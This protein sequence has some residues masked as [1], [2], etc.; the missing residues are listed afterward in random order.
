MLALA[1]DRAHGAFPYLVTPEHTRSARAILGPKRWLCVEQMILAETDPG[2]AREVGRRAVASYL[3]APGYR[4][5]LLRLG[6]T[7]DDVEARSVRLVDGLVAWG[8]DDAIRR[9]LDEHFAAGA[10]HVCVQAL[11]ADGVPGPDTAL[12]ERLSP[13]RG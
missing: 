10:D 13:S 12:L 5:N 8:D 4:D 3:T 11:R 6:F 2:K 1:R 7:L 9:R